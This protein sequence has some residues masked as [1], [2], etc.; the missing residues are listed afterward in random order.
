MLRDALRGVA[1]GA[2]GTTALDITTYG[3]MV[4]RGR[5]PSTVPA[6][7]A[8][9][10][11]AKLGVPLGADEVRRPNRERGLG[12]LLG[13]GAGLGVGAAYG[14]LRP[15]LGRWPAPVAALTLGLAAMATSD[16]PIG[17]LGVS[18][19]TAWSATDWISDLIPHLVYGL[20]A[21]VTYEALAEE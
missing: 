20:V 14:V 21:A 1:A 16:V 11:A 19:P 8:R 17:A 2:V 12:A 6:T 4:A 9:I 18:D 10:L 15:R 7:M 5:A 3:D 13:Y